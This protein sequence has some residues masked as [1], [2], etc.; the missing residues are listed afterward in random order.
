LITVFGVICLGASGEKHAMFLP[1][2]SNEKTG[3]YQ[4]FCDGYLMTVRFGLRDD[5]KEP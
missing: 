5:A 4:G 3:K 1:I 2:F